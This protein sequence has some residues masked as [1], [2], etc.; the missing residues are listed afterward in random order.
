MAC[1]RQRTGSGNWRLAAGGVEAGGLEAGGVEAGGVSSTKLAS[2]QVG[3]VK[4]N[5]TSGKLSR[6]GQCCCLSRRETR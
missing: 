2:A 3:V 6:V 4:N 5:M 1:C